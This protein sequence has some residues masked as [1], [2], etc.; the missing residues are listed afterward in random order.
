MKASIISDGNQQNYVEIF[1]KDNG[2]GITKE[3][4]EQLFK[5]SEN[6]ST[7]GTDGEAGTGLGLILCKEF[8]EKHGGRIWVE[9]EVGKGSEFIFTMSLIRAYKY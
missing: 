7:K 9:S 5:I 3:K 8:V 4:Q 6:V 2:V 1:V